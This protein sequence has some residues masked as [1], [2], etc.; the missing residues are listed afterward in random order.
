MY[1]KSHQRL[2]KEAYSVG[3]NFVV[4]R[5]GFRGVVEFSEN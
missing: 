5:R 1:S 4:S 3:S 2:A